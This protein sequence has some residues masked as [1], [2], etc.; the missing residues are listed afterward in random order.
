MKFPVL[1]AFAVVVGAAVVA[2]T[3]L[4]TADDAAVA[5]AVPLTPA[6]RGRELAAALGC[7][8]C[9]S[10]DGSPGIG[11]SWQGSYGVVRAFADGSFATV[12]ETYLRNSIREPGSLVVTGYQNVMLPAALTDAQIADTIALI[13][14][15]TPTTPP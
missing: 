13:R 10:L 14:D 6:E 11:P 1:L 7:V 8:A 12:D 5:S 15:L 2:A 3:L 4:W 9:H